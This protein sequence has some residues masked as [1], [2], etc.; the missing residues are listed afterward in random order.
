MDPGESS[1]YDEIPYGDNC[2]SDTH[3][4]H[5]ATLA[6]LYGLEPPP[7]ERCRVLELGCAGGGNLIPM[8]LE[9]PDG[10]FLGVDLSP[11]QIAAG[12]AIVAELRLRNV[13]LRAMDLATLDDRAGTFD[14]IICHGVYSWVPRVVRDAI[15][16]ICR[17]RLVRNGIA[18]VSYNTYPGWHGRGMVRELLAFHVRRSAPALDRVERAREFL[19][20]LVRVVPDKST[21]YARIL[22]TEGVFLGGVANSYLFHEHL[23]ETNHPLY[24]H[25][26]MARAEEKG[27][28]FVAE[29]RTPALIDGLPPDARAALD[30][31][32][33]DELAAEQYLDFLCNRTFRRT[34]LCHAGRE[35]SRVPST[36]RVASLW[37]ATSVVPVSDKPDTRSDAVEEFRRREDSSSVSTNNPVVKTA[38]VELHHLRPR[39]LAF[40]DLCH[41]I[42]ARLGPEQGGDPAAVRTALEGALLRCFLT[43]L[44]VLHTRPPRFAMEVSARPVASPLARIQARGGA[45]VTTLRR[46]TAEL[47]GFDRLALGLLD[48]SRDRPALLEAMAALIASGEFTIY[49]GDEPVRD[50]AVIREFLAAELGPCLERLA[51]MALLSV[52]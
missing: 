44:V 29:A 26:F 7:V 2:F 28:R 35:P 6:G 31:W 20:E 22:R 17:D 43:N 5:L 25:E 48:G 13:E 12:Q 1:S 11:R 40:D 15:L 8:A 32:A 51:A 36:P 49:H 23:E 16:A 37:V 14:Y 47:G 30:A 4:D 39:A 33:D 27:L 50:D 10:V 34:L 3:P 18:Y 45:R 46:R 38:L 41:R 42:S 9:N 19:D 52:A 21:A 24:F